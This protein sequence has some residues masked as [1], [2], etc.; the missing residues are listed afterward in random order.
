MHQKLV[1]EAP[2]P[3]LDRRSVDEL[4]ELCLAACRRIGYVGA[5]T[6]EFLYEGEQFY[7]IE[8]NTRLQVEHPV[9]E[10]V[11]CVDIVAAQLHI[12]LGEPLSLRQTDIVIGGHAIECRINAE[13]PVTFAPRPGTV[14]NINL[15]RGDGIRVDT[16]LRAG[17]V[18]P[19]HYDSLVAKLIVK[20][21]T[22]EAA[23]AR[24]R[25][26]LEGFAVEGIGT[27]LSLHRELLSDPEFVAG[28]ADIHHLEH[29][30]AE[31]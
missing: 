24:M 5:G 29:W 2:A 30:L 27:N 23:L 12:A 7:F 25:V 9:T 6:F 11:T 19:P 26:A 15:P 13:D 21:D 3:G 28:G 8:M 14:T 17:S 1:E 10:T 20:G 31:R 22:R 4:G 18:V 16:H